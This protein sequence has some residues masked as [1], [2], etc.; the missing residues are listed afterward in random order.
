MSEPIAVSTEVPQP[1]RS[2]DAVRHTWSERLDRFAT[3]G[4]TTAQFCAAEGVSVASFYLWKRRLTTPTPSALPEQSG[5]AGRPRLLPIR[6]PD[7]APVVELVLPGGP[8]LRIGP[9]TD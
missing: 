2:R 1:P 6:L 9:G 5:S 4:L 8:T 7:Q 3:A